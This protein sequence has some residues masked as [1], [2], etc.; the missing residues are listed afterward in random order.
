MGKFRL[1]ILRIRERKPERAL[2]FRSCGVEIPV[3]SD[4]A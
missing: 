1:K 3:V 4:I 2:A